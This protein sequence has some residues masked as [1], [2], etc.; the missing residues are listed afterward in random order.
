MYEMLSLNNGLKIALEHIPHV[1]SISIG[2][3]IKNGSRNESR[4]NNGI[5][6]FIEHMLFKGT[7]KRSAKEIVESIED[8]GGQLNAF[9]GKEA[10][11]YY[12]KVLDSHL[13][14]A[15]DVLSDML[16]NSKFDEEEIEKEKSVVLEEISMD[17]DNPEDVLSN[18]HYEGLFGKDSIAYPILGTKETVKS[19]TSDELKQFLKKQYT[20][21]NS[22]LSISG[23]FNKSEIYNLVN[24]YF[25]HWNNSLSHID[26][27]KPDIVNKNYFVKKDIE[28]VHL[29]VALKGFPIGHEDVYTLLMLSNLLGGG[30]SSILFQKLREELGMCYSIYA[31]PNSMVNI[32]NFYIYMG[33]NKRYVKD[34]LN[35]IE[36]EIKKFSNIKLSHEKLFKAKEQMKGNYILGLE[37]TSSRMFANGKA[38]LFLN[39]INTPKEILNYIEDINHE[40]IEHVMKE[41]FIPGI[42]NIALVG[43]DYDLVLNELKDKYEILNYKI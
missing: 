20:P 39:K 28:Q 8:I 38:A 4:E 18:I 15:L 14:L 41:I 36:E 21:E 16:F 7:D 13:D 9:T 1:Q 27:N 2:I 12:V 19:F 32:G 5:S 34:A 23:N 43:S 33:L 37:S 25:G 10:T 31:Y 29:S 6:H 22:V 24:R 26:Y 11:C 35:V 40:S 17:E 30:S 42:Q 3:W